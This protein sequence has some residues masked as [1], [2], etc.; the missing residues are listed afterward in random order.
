MAALM[1]SDARLQRPAARATTLGT[2][3]TMRAISTGLLA[4]LLVPTSAPV[5]SATVS[6]TDMH[7]DSTS[8][9][10]SVDGPRSAAPV[11]PVAPVAP[12]WGTHTDSLRAEALLP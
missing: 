9:V 2:G 10:P 4:L 6:V 1:L 8:S 12:A 7:G 11:A 5:P 3:G